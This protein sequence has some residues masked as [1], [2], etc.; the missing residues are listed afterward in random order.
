MTGTLTE[1]SGWS[2]ICPVLTEKLRDCEFAF[3]F[4]WEVPSHTPEV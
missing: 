4:T 3:Y 1:V 2:F